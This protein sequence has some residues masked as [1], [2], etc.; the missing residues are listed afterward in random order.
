MAIIKSDQSSDLNHDGGQ[1]FNRSTPS[2][3]QLVEQRQK[4]ANM[5][6]ETETVASCNY[7][8]GKLY[9]DT[10]TKVANRINGT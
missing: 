5:T 6:D 2:S 8:Y 4:C 10:L 7:T 1:V 9:R 3:S